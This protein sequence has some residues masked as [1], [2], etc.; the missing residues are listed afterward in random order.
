MKKLLLSAALLCAT[1]LSYAQMPDA[2]NWKEGDEITEQV[3]WGN[4]SFTDATLAPWKLIR[5]GG[6]TTETGGLFEVYDGR[7]VDLYQYVELPAGMYKVECQGYYRNGTSWA[8]DPS[9]F[10]TENWNDN[11]LLYV[12]N[13][14]YDITSDAFTA[15][16]T[17][18]IPL[19]PRL[20]PMWGSQIYE[21]TVKEGWDMSDG[22]YTVNGQSVWGPCSVPGSLLWFAEGIYGPYNDGDVKYNTVTF[23]LTEPGYARIGVRKTE[24][25]S[26]DSF[27]ATNFKMYYLGEAGPAAE[28]MALQDEVAEV[29]H[30]IETLENNSTGLLYTLVSDARMDFDG[31]DY[32]DIENL[33]KE[34]C[35]LALEE[36]KKLYNAALEAQVYYNYIVS[37][38]PVMQNLYNTTDYAGKPAFAAALQNAKNCIDENYEATAEDDF[39][40]FKAAYENVSAARFAYLMS[41]KSE[42]GAYDFSST[43]NNAFMCNNEYTPKWDAEANCYK[44]IQEI[45][46]TYSTIQEQDYAGIRNEHPDWIDYA[47]NF[48]ITEKDCEGQWVIKSTTWHG[49]AIGITQQHGYPAIG[50]WTAEPTGNP[51]I[52]YQNI[53]GLPN[54]YYSMT[55]LMCNA[56]A[57]L[58]PLQYVFIESGDAKEIANLTQRGDPWWGGNRDLWRQTVWEK[59]ST[60]MVYVSDGKVKIGSSSDAFY[61]T[62]GFQLFYYGENPDF[63]ALIAPS[64]AEVKEAI[65]GLTFV[66]DKAAA[67]AILNA[68][69]AV[70]EGQEGYLAALE[71]IKSAKNYIATANREVDYFNNTTINNFGMF[72]ESF[73]DGSDESLIAQTAFLTAVCVG[74]NET[75]TYK[76]A[77]AAGKD[78]NAYLS[79]MDYRKTAMQY[80]SDAAVSEVIASQTS[81]LKN[82]YANAA[83]MAELKAELAKPYNA[84]LLASVGTEGATAEKPVDVTAL[85]INPNFDEL[86]KGWDGEM[87]VDSLGTVERW[88]VNCNVSQTIYSLPAGVYRVVAQ[89]FYRDGG[90]AQGAYQNYWYLLDEETGEWAN[91]NAKLYAN[92]KETSIA[93]I[94]SESFADRSYTEYVDRWDAA[95]DGDEQ[96]N[97]VYEPHWTYQFKKE[98]KDDT[99]GEISYEELDESNVSND[100][101]W[102][103]KVEDIDEIL[104]YPASLRGTAVRFAKNPEAYKNSVEAYVEEGGSLTFGV[105]KEVLIANDWVTFD[106]FK[107]Y[108]LGNSESVAIESAQTSNSAKAIFTIAGTRKANATKGIN[109][110]KMSNGTVRKIFVK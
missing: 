15:G 54:G 16:R 5:N 33:T 109:I 46:D 28:L 3:S 66:G 84:A 43:I 95:A 23:F 52:L 14:T 103:T 35:P 89:A 67:T 75:D 58:S 79:Y 99:T 48:A 17:F 105:K 12:S 47:G 62:T 100:Y 65:E 29:Y 11:A 63:A 101:P 94:A 38:L 34:E 44:F 40:T 19:M 51:E 76:D 39:G 18:K 110:V 25:R 31:S 2:S 87:T 80:I 45:E 97:I 9:T 27:M 49:G 57:E 4:L 88:N 32:A 70:I 74:E 92:E 36:L 107:L 42:T 37:V 6:S 98:V 30:Q 64:V 24:P 69:P 91:P 83:K 90:D 72:A 82:N 26:A 59:L 1:A 21:D 22:N 73:A 61:A 50:G 108:Y 13:G 93:S 102:D 81:Y 41:E 68:I 8:D 86:S 60:N 78:Y 20:F 10:G 56:G 71:T 77:I 55:G 85:I 53:T 96:G 106:N 104:F 7:E